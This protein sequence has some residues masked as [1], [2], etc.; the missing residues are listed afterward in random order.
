MRV[1]VISGSMGAGKTT[2]LGEASDLLSAAAIPHAAIDLDGIA[3]VHVPP[4]VAAT[5]RAQNLRSLA[6]HF[7]AAGIARM[8]I[9]EAVESRESRDWL[10]ATIDAEMLRVC[11]LRAAV[12]T[13]QQR[14]RLREPGM[15][16]QAFVERVLTLEEALDAGGVEDYSVTN[17]ARP[18]TEVAREVLRRADWLS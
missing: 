4:A 14:I 17:D 13:M 2:V 3:A 5:I 15:L 6:E 10:R 1:L 11:R 8:L 9:A 16:Q 18:V 7:R 12:A